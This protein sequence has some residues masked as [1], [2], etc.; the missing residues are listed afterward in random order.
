MKKYKII[1]AYDGTDYYGW[2]IQPGHITVVGVLQNTFK[3]VF[4]REILM[5]GASRTDAGVHALGQTAVFSTDL[6]ITAEQLLFAWQNVLPPCKCT[7]KNLLL[8]LFSNQAAAHECA[9]WLLLSPSG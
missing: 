7:T 8:S 3:A 1:I 9:V 5:A 2:Q 4:G 6:I